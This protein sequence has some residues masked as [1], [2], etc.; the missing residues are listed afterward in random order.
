VELGTSVREDP[1]RA[2]IAL[3]RL[4][5]RLDCKLGGGPMALK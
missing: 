2:A 4:V 5:E 3:D 1:F